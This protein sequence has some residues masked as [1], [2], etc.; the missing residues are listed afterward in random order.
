MGMIRPI[1]GGIMAARLTALT[2]LVASLYISN[3]AFGQMTADEAAAALA[4]REAARAATTQPDD[5]TAQIQMLRSIIADQ[6]KQIADL[7]AKIK[8]LE[9]PAPPAQMANNVHPKSTF[10]SRAQDRIDTDNPFV[11]NG[12]EDTEKEKKFVNNARQTDAAIDAYAAANNLPPEMIE[13]MH[14]GRPL[15]KMPEAALS[16]FTEC[17]TESESVTGKIKQ[18]WSVDSVGLP[19]YT[20][21]IADGYVVEI[22]HP[23]PLSPGPTGFF[24]PP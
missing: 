11:K 12:R 8:S 3:V 21:V 14:E 18:V 15:L 2:V 4:Q 5:Q 16:L 10:T 7:Q 22:E 20:V 1:P 23:E 13:A 24:N 17:H 6:R 9:A 19:T